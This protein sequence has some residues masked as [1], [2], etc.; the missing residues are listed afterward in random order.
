MLISHPHRF[1]FVHIPKT[2]GI[3][4]EAALLPYATYGKVHYYL[5]K[6]LRRL[7]RDRKIPVLLPERYNP[8]PMWHHV[9]AQQIVEKIGREQFV[10]Y[11]SFAVVRNPWDRLV[12]QYHFILRDQFHPAHEKVRQFK[13]FTEYLLW[14]YTD[15]PADLQKRYIFSDDGE[16]LVD[17]ICHFETLQ[18]DFQYVCDKI[19]IRATLPAINIGKHRPYQEYYNKD[20]ITLVSQV[21]SPDIETFGYTFTTTS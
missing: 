8:Q 3:S 21:F 9:T 14:R 11:F 4:I 7:N 20:T 10:R 17:F 6:V 18:Q 13:D 19:G 12:S 15:K 2:A 16:Q 5:F 1:I